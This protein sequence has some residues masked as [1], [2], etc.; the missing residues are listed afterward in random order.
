MQVAGSLARGIEL[1]SPEHK[2]N[3]YR[4]F[5]AAYNSQIAGLGFGRCC[6]GGAKRAT[7]TTAI[8]RGHH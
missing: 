2:V 1:L 3:G 6:R 5:E 7:T 8:R 4:Q